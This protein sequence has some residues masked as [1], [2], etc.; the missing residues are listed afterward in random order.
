M[1]DRRDEAIAEAR[2]AEQTVMRNAPLGSLHGVPYSAK[3]LVN[4]RGVRTTFG[5][6][7]FADNVPG[8]DA[9][10]IARLRAAG[11]I[12]IG[13]T[14]TPEFGTKCLTDA[15]CSAARAM[16]GAPA[17]AAVAR[18]LCRTRRGGI[19]RSGRAP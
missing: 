2:A 15:P 14:T 19:G 8:E 17:M 1:P 16:H 12:L 9:V 18:G 10:A 6:Q 4:T 11:A 13:K 3:D 5:S 7:I